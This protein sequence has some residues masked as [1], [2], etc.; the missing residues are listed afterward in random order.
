MVDTHAHIALCEGD[1]AAVVGRAADAGVTRILTVGLDE[2]SNRDVVRLA[3]EHEAVWA[4]VGRH[5][6][7]AS[8]WDEAA[9]AELRELAADERVVAVG[10]TGLDFYRDMAS[11][12][13]QL[14]AFRSQIG[15]AREV[16]KPLV[17]HM[18]SG[19]GPGGDAVAESFDLLALEAA[20]VDV[21]L[22]CF[23]APPERVAEAV[24]NRWFCS[25]AG[26]VTYPKAEGLREAA[27][28]VP[29]DLLLVET[30]SPYLA[31]Q[32]RRGKPNEPALV[33]E[34]AREVAAAR[35]VSPDELDATVEENARRVFGW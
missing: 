29:D 19:E 11:R 23:S 2:E 7:S 27:R 18:R 31:P 5:P 17:I 35:G 21:V 12:E 13:D 6:N 14:A 1:P 33:V 26:N 3:G 20:G 34:T 32:S 4:A 16:S 30:D 8:G 15:I 9:E 28:L 10:E 25:F 22:H 24:A